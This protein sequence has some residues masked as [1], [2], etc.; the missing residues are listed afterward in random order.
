[1]AKHPFLRQEKALH[2][3]FWAEYFTELNREDNRD[4]CSLPKYFTLIAL[5]KRTQKKQ[6]RLH[7]LLITNNINN[8][9]D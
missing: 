5:I 8:H 9:N 2:L 7:N 1:M 3:Q 6:F 4:R